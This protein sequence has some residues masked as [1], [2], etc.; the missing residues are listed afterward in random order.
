MIAIERLR[1]NFGEKVAVDIEAKTGK[2]LQAH[3]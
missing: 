3:L 1:K 2:A